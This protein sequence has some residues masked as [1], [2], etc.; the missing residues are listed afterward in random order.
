MHPQFHDLIAGRSFAT[1]KKLVDAANGLMELL[2]RRLEYVYL[3]LSR[4]IRLLEIW[5]FTVG[6]RRDRHPVTGSSVATWT[7]TALGAPAAHPWPVHPAAI[8]LSYYRD[9]IG[10]ATVS[11][12][13]RHMGLHGPILQRP[14]NHPS[15][16]NSQIFCHRC[17]GVG[18]TS[19]Q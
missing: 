4:Q 5:R 15:H 17:W 19:G 1:F 14:A 12:T 18:H 6:R 7:S 3:L 2:R 16:H 9:H 11:G 13:P 10:A 8:Q